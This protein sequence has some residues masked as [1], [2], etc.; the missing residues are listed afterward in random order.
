VSYGVAEKGVAEKGLM[1]KK[2]H[3]RALPGFIDIRL[4]LIDYRDS[5]IRCAFA[6]RRAS[7]RLDK[8]RWRS[9]T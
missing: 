6:C 3:D 2:P 9:A 7:C 4:W 1:V 8:P 5:L